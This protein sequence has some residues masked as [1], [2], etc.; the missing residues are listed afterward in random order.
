VRES[1]RER[2]RKKLITE[3]YDVGCPEVILYVIF[4]AAVKSTNRKSIMEPIESGL[5]KL[6]GLT[7]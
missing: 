7:M 6:Y 1:E 2:Y 3:Q 4:C 5:V